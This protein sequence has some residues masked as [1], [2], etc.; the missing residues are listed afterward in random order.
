MG[1][2][3]VMEE[4]A[5]AADKKKLLEEASKT[6]AACGCCGSR[7]SSGRAMEEGHRRFYE[8]RIDQAVTEAKSSK[9]RGSVTEVTDVEANAKTVLTA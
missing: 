5:A 3:S 7:S 2:M 9:R 1:A 4:D 6:E 8:D